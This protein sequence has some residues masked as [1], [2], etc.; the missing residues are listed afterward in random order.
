MPLRGQT[1]TGALERAPGPHAVFV[2]A[3][4]VITVLGTPMTF[5]VISGRCAAYE[6]GVEVL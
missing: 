4:R 3:P 6:K 1:P 2:G 5:A